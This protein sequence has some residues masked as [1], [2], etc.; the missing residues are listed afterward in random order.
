MSVIF[1]KDDRKINTVNPTDP[2]LF[3]LHTKFHL[4][5]ILLRTWHV[6]WK[7]PSRRRMKYNFV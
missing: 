5:V 1:I 2:Q 7:A 3:D 6:E 4:N